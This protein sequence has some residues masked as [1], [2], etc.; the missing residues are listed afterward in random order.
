MTHIVLLGDSIFDNA[1]YVRGGPD[2]IAQLREVLPQGARAT[3]LAVD[4][5]VA[6]GVASQL[7]RLPDDATRLVVS[8][9]GNDA[10]GASGILMQ[11]VRS[12]GEAV[13]LLAQAQARFAANYDAMVEGVVA[14]GVPAALCTIYDTP[15]TAPDHHVI[16]T[17][18]A[19]FNDVITRAA[20]R[21]RLP[22]VDLRLIC[23]NPGDYANPIE[24]GVQGGAKIAA[25]LA[26]LA[27]PEAEA[28]RSF[29]LAGEGA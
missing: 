20:F 14:T 6:S 17:A 28:G 16:R 27:Q 13:A 21:H 8:A 24:P 2:V 15:S 4:G 12:V 1:A 25:E 7:R 9:G 3:L 18:L 23:D 5:A 19:V 11:S 26:R 29:V 22:L 10:L